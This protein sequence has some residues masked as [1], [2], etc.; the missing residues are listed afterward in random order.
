MKVIA[1][2]ITPLPEDLKAL[3]VDARRPC[4]TK[5]HVHTARFDDGCW[6]CVGI[7]WMTILWLFHVKE[8]EVSKDLAGFTVDTER[9]ELPAIRCRCGHPDLIAQ[10]DRGGPATIVNGCF[11]DNVLLFVPLQGQVHCL[12][13]PVAIRTEK[14]RPVV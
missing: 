3:R 9:V 12:G 13:V 2:N 14:L 6:R 10:D 8:F 1:P 7:E 5:S 11:P 4:R